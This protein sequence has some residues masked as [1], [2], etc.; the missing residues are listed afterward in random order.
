MIK[1]VKL[2]GFDTL[3]V[4]TFKNTSTGTIE[5]AVC[6]SKGIAADECEKLNR[7]DN[8]QILA[9]NDAIVYGAK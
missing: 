6:A 5:N 3:I 7:L 8:I 1:S 9:M 4:I 2:S